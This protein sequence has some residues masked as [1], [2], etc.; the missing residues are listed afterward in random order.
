M[1]NNLCPAA[2][3]FLDDLSDGAEIIAI[4]ENNDK[5]TNNECAFMVYGFKNG[6][7]AATAVYNSNENNGYVPIELRSE[8]P[9]LEPTTPYQ[10]LI[11]DYATTRAAFDN[12]FANP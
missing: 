3:S 2:L 10:L 11:T 6:L 8:E 9:N 7:K 4:V 12:L 5:G 1:V